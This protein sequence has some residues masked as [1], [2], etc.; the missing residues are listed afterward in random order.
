MK[1]IT[2]H[3]FKILFLLHFLLM[4][5]ISPVLASD[6]GVFKT[7]KDLATAVYDREDGDNIFSVGAMVL[8]EKGHQPRIDLIKSVVENRLLK[9]MGI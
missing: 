7:G 4:L 1:I 3:F 6:M 9:I 5:M 8:I 2:N